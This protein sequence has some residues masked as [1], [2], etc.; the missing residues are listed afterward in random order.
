MLYKASATPRSAAPGAALGAEPGSVRGS[1]DGGLPGGEQTP[2]ASREE[3]Q[4]QRLQQPQHAAGPARQLQHEEEPAA[5]PS[6]VAPAPARPAAAAKPAGSRLPAPPA[7]ASRLRP[8]TTSSGYFSSAATNSTRCG[9]GAGV[10]QHLGH[11]VWQGTMHP[12]GHRLLAFNNGHHWPIPLVLCAGR[13]RDQ[14]GEQLARHGQQPPPAGQQQAPGQQQLV[15]VP[16]QRPS[17]WSGQA[18]HQP[19]SS[20]P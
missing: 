10:G 12:R 13:R 16:G 7:R 3:V 5:G 11:A 9:W 8:P 4:P 17:L 6:H 19:P 2:A 14:W 1:H 20:L 15:Q 18:Q